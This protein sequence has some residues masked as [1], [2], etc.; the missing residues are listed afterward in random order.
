[1]LEAIIS[2]FVFICAT[3]IVL[4]WVV[5]F[6]DDYAGLDDLIIYTLFFPAG[7]F[8]GWLS[9]FDLDIF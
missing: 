7:V 9:I 6:F 4:F 2:L 8:Y 5:W 1:M 3:G